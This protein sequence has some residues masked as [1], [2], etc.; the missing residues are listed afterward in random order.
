MYVVTG[1]AGF[2]GSN[3]AAVLLRVHFVRRVNRGLKRRVGQP[4]PFD[5]CEDGVGPGVRERSG[6]DRKKVRERA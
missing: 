1:G 5:R 6:I 4:V 3:L 2:I